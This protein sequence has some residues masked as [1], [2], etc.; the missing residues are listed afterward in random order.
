MTEKLN[1]INLQV[2]HWKDV[3]DKCFRH[4]ALASWVHGSIWNEKL[5]SGNY[6]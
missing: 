4:E 5:K 3:E 1:N 6:D 2:V